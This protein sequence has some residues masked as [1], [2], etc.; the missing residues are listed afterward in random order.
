MLRRNGGFAL[1]ELLL[2][3]MMAA[4]L[5]AAVAMV[6][7]EQRQDRTITER[8]G[9]MAQYVN[10]VAAYMA[11]QGATPPANLTQDGTDWLKSRTCTGNPAHMPPDAYFLACNVPTNFNQVYD[12]GATALGEPRVV[13]DWATTP[14]APTATIDFGTVQTGGE[15]NAK[16]AASLA[17]EINRKLEAD[18]YE[19]ISAFTVDL[20]AVDLS[21]AAAVN[22][23]VTSA[24][25]R[26]EIDTSIESTTFVRRDGNTVMTGPLINENDNWSL[27]GRDSDGIENANPQDPIASANLNDLYIRASDTWLSETHELAEEAYRLAIRSPL[28]VASVRSGTTITKPGCPAPL[29]P[30]IIATPAGFLGGD[31]A[32]TKLLAGVR[33]RVVNSA[34]SWRIWMDTSYDGSGGFTPVPNNSDIGLIQVTVKCT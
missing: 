12:L 25:L 6:L 21:D 19:F 20:D 27:I 32:N 5:F 29:T 4:T 1:A 17:A 16:I 26:A 3:A 2:A 18:A 10:A 7:Q 9:W 22:A 14:T 13:F 31:T 15:A 33:T 24:N 28:L 34:G 11:A 30:E 23:A 8:A